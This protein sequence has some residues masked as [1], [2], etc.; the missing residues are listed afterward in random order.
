MKLFFTFLSTFFLVGTIIAQQVTFCEDFEGYQNGNP[1]AQTSPSWNTWGELMSG[2]SAPFTDDANVS[3]VLSSSGINS[4][5]LF[6][7]ATQGNQDII[8]PFGS[9]TPYTTGTFEFVSNFYVNP[10]TGA[11]FNF[12]ADNIPGSTWSLDV[13][14]DLGTIV[15]E[16]TGSGLNYLTASYPEGVWFELKIIANLTTNNW[17]LFIDNQSLGSFTN[18]VNQIASLDLY[19]IIGHQFYV[20]DVCYTYTPFIPLAYDMAAIDLNMVSNLALTSAPF[21]VSGDVVSISATTITSLDINYSINGG[22]PVVDNLSGLNLALFDT[23]TF[24]HNIIWNP[25]T[26][27][28]YFVEIWASNLNGNPDMDPSNDYFSDS[29]HIWNALAVR[30]PLIETFTSSTCG[31]CNPANV[32]A[33]ALFTQNPGKITSIKYQEDFPGSGDPYYTIETGNRRAY[34]AI[35]SVPRMEIDGGWDQN[36]N[37]IT[38][39]IID[40]YGDELCLIDLSSVYSVTGKTV[41]IDITIDPLENFNSNNL[42][43]HSAIIEE[44][45]YNNIKNNGETQF[46]HVVKKMVPSDIGTPISNL[47][48]TQQVTLNL[49]HI[50]QGNYRLPFD[51]SSP[52]NH[53]IEHSVED[54]SNLMVAV[55]IQDAVTKEVHQSTYA[56]LSSFTPVT[57][58]CI[59]EACVD[60]GTGNGQYTTLTSCESICISTSVEENSK[61]IQLIYPNPATDKIYISNL[62]EDNTLVKIY[63]INGRLVLENKIS[64]NEYLNISNISKGIYQI[65]F[66]GSDWNEMRKLIKE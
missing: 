17:E 7:G 23:L 54:F 44:T 58:D 55:W 39:Q 31:P 5:Y 45:T 56:T 16:N 10:S 28:S 18:T 53:T 14:M 32:T 42:V 66:E 24:N 13:K 37:N 49:Q 46:E 33:E 48:A 50:F 43:V 19:P 20:D 11:Y 59:N 2:T 26:T 22:A 61:T 9:G 6:S 15:V 21:T 29:I 38:Q 64:N 27:G 34:Y 4:L 25:T 3:S 57:Y 12:Q 63:D 47:G 51:A 1:I 8:L 36:G 60:P 52:I 35:N 30:Q 65:K 40:D 41:D 62:K